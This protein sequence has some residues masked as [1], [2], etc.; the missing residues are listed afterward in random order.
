[1]E[2]QSIR[3]KFGITDPRITVE[4]IGKY[5]TLPAGKEYFSIPIQNSVISTRDQIVKLTHICH[6]N[7]SVFCHVQNS[8]TLFYFY[9]GMPNINHTSYYDKSNGEISVDFF[10]L[11]EI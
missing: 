9:P 2:E 6:G 1:M 5:Y 11:V 7:N 3:V 8:S 10:S 4:L